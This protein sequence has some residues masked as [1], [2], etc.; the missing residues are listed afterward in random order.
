MNRS[1]FAVAVVEDEDSLRS[2]IAHLVASAGFSVHE[3]ACADDLDDLAARITPSLIVI[4][5]GL[6]GENGLAL[7]RRYTDS[8]PGLFTIILTAH[9]APVE[10]VAAYRSGASLF[11]PK[12]FDGD[13]L[14]AIVESRFRLAD[15]QRPEIRQ[16]L[17]LKELSLEGPLGS[18]LLSPNEARLLGAFAVAPDR[19]LE[20]YRIGEVLAL[21]ESAD[22]SKGAIEL[23]ISRLRAK[24]RRTVADPQ[25]IRSIY[26]FGYKLVLPVEIG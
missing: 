18:V 12:P 6:P 11:L 17:L 10:R 21:R 23:A 25:P 15:R 1:D 8:M 19:T 5:I 14:L 26:R 7:C 24:L 2:E 3:A 22:M 13:E 9:T 4:D 20:A 16:G